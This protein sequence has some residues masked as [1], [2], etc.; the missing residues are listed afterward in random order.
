MSVPTDRKYNSKHY[1]VKIVG[2]EAIIGKTDYGQQ[3][4]GTVTGVNIAT[5]GLTLS[6][7]A[8]FGTITATQTSDL[9]MPIG[10]DVDSRNSQLD[11]TPGLVNSSPYADGWL[12]KV[13]NYDGDEVDELLDHGEYDKV[14]DD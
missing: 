8:K 1:W 9:E 4:L 6:Q 11:T 10:G 5:V 7:D 12:I 3:R 13:K 2:N 14:I